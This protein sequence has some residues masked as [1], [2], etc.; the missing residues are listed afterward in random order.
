MIVFIVTMAC[1]LL[2]WQSVYN[3]MVKKKCFTIYVYFIFTRKKNKRVFRRFLR[4]FSKF[5][6]LQNFVFSFDPYGILL[7]DIKYYALLFFFLLYIFKCNV[8]KNILPKT[9]CPSLKILNY[10]P[11][12]KYYFNLLEY[13]WVATRRPCAV[14][15]KV[16]YLPKVRVINYY[17]QILRNNGNK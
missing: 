14:K 2:S 3:L 10:W 9:F 6:R 12:R 17:K 16:F 13:F 11:Q 4:L 15:L 1:V 8:R 7:R 5:K